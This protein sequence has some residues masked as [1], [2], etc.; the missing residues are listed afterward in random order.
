MKNL[1]AVSLLV[2][3]FGFPALGQS[4][5]EKQRQFDFWIGE[6]DVNLRVQQED[7]SWKDSIKAV[8]HIYSILEGKAILEL[9]SAGKDGING[10]SLRYYNPNTDKW[11]LW[12]NWPGKNRSGTNGLNGSF[13]HGRGEFF[14]QSKI[15]EKTTQI[16]R[17][18]FSD[19]TPNSLR[20]DDGYSRDGGKTWSS[21]WIMEFS[22]RKPAP[23]PIAENKNLHT[24]FSGARC[25]L[26]GFE[27]LKIAANEHTNGPDLRV[28]NILDGCVV[29]GLSDDFFFTLTYNT[30][31]SVYEL[32]YL[33][34]DAQA[35]FRLFYGQADGDTL[36][37]RTSRRAGTEPLKAV[38]ELS[39]GISKIEVETM[40]AELMPVQ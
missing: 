32:G 13:R 24:Y 26:P 28:Y 7:K 3:S 38:I 10:Y 40:K 23:P 15:D 11:D 37:L 8:A 25:D 33:E 35:P 1:F 20:W 16:R 2:F 36:Q 30:Y 17:Y 31:A 21:N 12:L 9:W 27:K 29:L 5:E 19:V 39:S 22:R 14:A 6:W 18:T 34:K 4:T